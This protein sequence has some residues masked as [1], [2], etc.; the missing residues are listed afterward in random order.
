MPS[1][2]VC[3]AAPMAATGPEDRAGAGPDGTAACP[4][5]RQACVSKTKQGSNGPGVQHALVRSLTEMTCILLC[6]CVKFRLAWHFE[7][8]RTTISTKVRVPKFKP[9]LRKNLMRSLFLSTVLDVMHCLVRG[10]QPLPCTL[11]HWQ[12]MPSACRTPQM[13]RKYSLNCFI[14]GHSGAQE[15]GTADAC[16]Q[17][18]PYKA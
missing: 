5:G 1:P 9:K 10:W 15:Q 2:S 17:L 7:H 11:F 16:K 14:H 6:L 13:D 12:I 8:T 18:N 4:V 3:A